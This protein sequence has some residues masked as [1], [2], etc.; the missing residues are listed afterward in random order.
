[1][2]IAIVTVPYVSNDLHLTFTM[3]TIGSIKTQ[4]EVDLIGIVNHSREQGQEQI[5]FEENFDHLEYNDRNNLSRAWNKG[6]EIA[7]KRG[8]DY[9][10]VPN[11]DVIFNE[12]CIDN[13]VKFAEEHQDAIMWTGSEW[14]NRETIKEAEWDES[15]DEHPHFSCFLVKND[16]VD[17]LGKVDVDKENK[18]RFDEQYEP[19]YNED[20][21]MHYRIKLAG[22][23]AL[24]TATAKFF[25][26]GSRT[27]KSDHDLEVNNVRTHGQNNLKHV[28]KWGGMPGQEVFK[29]PYNK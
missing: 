22:E 16:F 7:V 25:H 12:H 27:I 20:N 3:E 24:K 4:H 10:M 29:T 17:R 15:F 21:D 26:Y 14:E 23:K 13:L 6:I 18:G 2:K 1:M 11:L 5:Y 28:Q 19:A 8:A 9:V